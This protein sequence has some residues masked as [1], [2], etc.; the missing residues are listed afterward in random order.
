[1]AATVSV[2]M[3]VYNRAPVV[4]RA[5]ASVLRQDYADL[6]L[7]VADDGSTDDTTAVIGAVKDPRVRLLRLERNIGAAA[8]RNEALKAATG[9]FIAF[10]DSDDEW[11]PDKLSAQ[12]ACFQALPDEYGAVYCPME[13]IGRE[14]SKLVPRPGTGPLQGDLH[15]R[16][17]AGNFIGLPSAL[18]KKEILAKSGLFDPA[19]P[20]LQDWD[21]W[22]RISAQSMF[23]FVDKPLVKAFYSSD[24]ISIDIPKVE[25]AL[26]MIIDKHHEDF[27]RHP[28]ALGTSYARLGG[29]ALYLGKRGTAIGHALSA[30]K[31]FPLCTKAYR[32]L[33]AAALPLAVYRPLA[34]RSHG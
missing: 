23:G 8:A 13:R 29:Y 4:G 27:L 26:G 7:L 31:A 12:M 6:E 34:R 28:R 9:A 17:L 33:A 18:V 21:L 1:M 5:L 24:S 14:G 30:L 19:L 32:L 20:C 22:I 15:S 16:L 11:L 2:I 3:P 25:Q 10:Q